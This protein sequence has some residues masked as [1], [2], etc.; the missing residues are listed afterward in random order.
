MQLG[1]HFIR[2]GIHRTGGKL[3][4]D[5]VPH[6]PHF[7]RHDLPENVIDCL[8]HLA[9]AAEI[10]PQGNQGRITGFFRGVGRIPA[11]FFH[12][13]LRHR[14]A[15]AIDALL[16]IADHEHIHTIGQFAFI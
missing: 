4:R 8:R 12:K 6:A 13:Q 7:R 9:A 14:L 15:E 1:G 11:E 5:V 2:R 10:C 16:H 3:L